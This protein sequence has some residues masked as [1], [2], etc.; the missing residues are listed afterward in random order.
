MHT[1]PR[2]A[3]GKGCISAPVTAGT[4][5]GLVGGV[6]AGY[7]ILLAPGEGLG[8]INRPATCN[9]KPHQ[10]FSLFTKLIVF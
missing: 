1:W 4:G 6:T 3:G 7:E 5:L 8:E 10:I 2:R 9:N